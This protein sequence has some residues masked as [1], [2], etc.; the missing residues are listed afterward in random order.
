MALTAPERTLL[1]SIGSGTDRRAGIMSEIVTALGVTGLL[2]RDTFSWLALTNDGRAALWV[3]LQKLRAALL[4]SRLGELSRIVSSKADIRNESYR[5]CKR[6][7]PYAVAT[8][9]PTSSTP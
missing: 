1:F 7:T 9:T 3:L 8:P 5:K 6:A 2:V 4:I